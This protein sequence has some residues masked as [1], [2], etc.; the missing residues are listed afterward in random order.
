MVNNLE[1]LVVHQL[2]M[3]LGLFCI[4]GVSYL[5]FNLLLKHK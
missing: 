3:F 1:E 5:I 4:I 2:S